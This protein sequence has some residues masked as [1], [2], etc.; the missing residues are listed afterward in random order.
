MEKQSNTDISHSSGKVF[1]KSSIF[2]GFLRFRAYEARIRP[3]ESGGTV[4]L[5]G[6]D[7]L[8]TLEFLVEPFCADRQI[9]RGFEHRLS[10]NYLR[11]LPNG[12]RS[13]L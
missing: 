9:R 11:H 2:R 6:M 10:Q 5:A 13:T 8:L 12:L 3:D 4:R 1:N 7:Q